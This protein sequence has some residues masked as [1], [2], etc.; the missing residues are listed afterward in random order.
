LPTADRYD[1]AIEF[2]QPSWGSEGPWEILEPLQYRG[3][4]D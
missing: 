4:N 2:R 1:Y 3:L